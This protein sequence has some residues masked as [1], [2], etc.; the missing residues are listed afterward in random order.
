MADTGATSG[1]GESLR[2]MW[3]A[4]GGYTLLLVMKLTAYFITHVGVLFAES[5]HSIADV[6]IVVFLLVAAYYSRRPRDEDYRF[7][8]GRAQNIAALVAATIFISFTS[9]ETLREAIPKLFAGGSEHY[10]NL[11]IALAVIAISIVV[12]AVPLWSILQEKRRGAAMRAQLVETINDLIALGAALIG[13]IFIIE[14]VPIADPIASIV[15]ALVIAFN[16]VIL[17]RENARDLM[18]RSPGPEYAQLIHDAAMSVPGVIDVHGLIAEVVGGQTHLSFHMC[19]AKGTLIE[20]ADRIAHDVRDVVL[21]ASPMTFL[22]IHT[23]PEGGI[24]GKGVDSADE[25]FSLEGG[26]QDA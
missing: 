2:G 24:D 14:G 26:S 19:V 4:L 3:L 21:A 1:G 22:V 9:L 6:L 11:S 16:A 13:T 23:D 5:M 18:G 20:D 17:W 12:S 15:V 7:G 25:W 8:Y 10:D